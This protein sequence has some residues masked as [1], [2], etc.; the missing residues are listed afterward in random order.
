MK[1]FSFKNEIVLLAAPPVLPPVVLSGFASGDD[2]A[3]MGYNSDRAMPKV[4]ADGRAAIALSADNTAKVVLKFMMTSGANKT[5]N[6]LANLQ[7][8]PLTAV[9]LILTVQN[10]YRQDRFAMVGGVITKVPDFQRGAGIN[11]YAWELFFEGFDPAIQ[12]PLFVGLATSIAEG[13]SF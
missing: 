13:Q 11:E 3:T 7:K 6:N 10:V 4:G 1:L 12:D 5:L 8:N 2:A 9:P